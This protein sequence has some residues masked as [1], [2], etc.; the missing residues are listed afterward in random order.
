MAIFLFVKYAAFS[1]AFS[2]LFL[3]LDEKSRNGNRHHIEGF[4][5]IVLGDL[6]IV[7]LRGS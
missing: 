4:K 2:F 1:L 7:T 5:K 3:N 6:F